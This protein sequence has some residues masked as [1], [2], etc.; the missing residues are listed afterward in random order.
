MDQRDIKRAIQMPNNIINDSMY[1][2][3][4]NCFK[5]WKI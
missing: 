3:A 4:K 1:G 2:L 5:C